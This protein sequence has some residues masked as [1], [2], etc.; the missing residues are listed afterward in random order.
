MAKS[1]GSLFEPEYYSDTQLPGTEHRPLASPVPLVGGG[2][3]DNLRFVSDFVC[4]KL[5]TASPP[6]EERETAQSALAEGVC[7]CVCVH[8][9]MRAC[10]RVCVRVCV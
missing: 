2:M 6:G 3:S 8:V 7:L 9:C 1:V 4:G 10:M 5:D